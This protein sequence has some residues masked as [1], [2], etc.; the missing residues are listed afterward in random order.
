MTGV[1]TCALPICAEAPSTIRTGLE[2]ALTEKYMGFKKTV[3]A[4]KKGGSAENP[5]AV[6]AAIGRKKYGKAAFQKAAAAGKKMGEGEQLDELSPE[7]K[8]R[9]YNKAR[10]DIADRAREVGGYDEDPAH[11]DNMRAINNRYAGMARA[12]NKAPKLPGQTESAIMEKAPPGMEDMVLKL[13][14]QYPGHPEKA[15]A[16]AWMI[17]NKTHGKKESV[18][19]EVCNECG[20][21]ESE[22]GC[23]HGHM[24]EDYK[25]KGKAY[26]GA[27]Q[28]DDDEDEDDDDDKK[29][30]STEKKSRG[31][32]KKA[33]HEKSSAK[34]PKFG[35]GKHELPQHQGRVWGKKDDKSF[36]YASGA[37]RKKS[38]KTESYSAYADRYNQLTEGVNYKKIGRAHV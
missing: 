29:S 12:D 31:R 15:F 25:H 22:C 32:P 1:Q 11:A 21:Y 5:E 34:L 14:K 3:A 24:N 30:K 8:T 2:T 20:M 7:L 9:Y 19:E 27:A 13:K 38:K 4:I 10:A 26:G 17:Y 36:D 6:A 37:D 28:H 35:S 23:D 33:E 16:T 18:E